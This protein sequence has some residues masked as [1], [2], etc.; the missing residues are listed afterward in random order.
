MLERERKLVLIEANPPSAYFKYVNYAFEKMGPTKI[1]SG[2]N[3]GITKYYKHI[4]KATGVGVGNI[5][6]M[7]KDYKNKITG[8]FCYLVLYL[9]AEDIINLIISDIKANAALRQEL[10]ARIGKGVKYID[11]LFQNQLIALDWFSKNDNNV[12]NREAAFDLHN[13]LKAITDVIE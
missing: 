9:K 1:F 8:D 7:F 10:I 3:A 11:F 6:K 5:K 13:R 4:S 2:N 12:A